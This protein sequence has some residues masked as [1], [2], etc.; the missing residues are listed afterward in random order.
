MIEVNKI[1]TFKEPKATSMALIVN[2]TVVGI[3]HY[4]YYI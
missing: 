1:A 4:K 2:I 3:I